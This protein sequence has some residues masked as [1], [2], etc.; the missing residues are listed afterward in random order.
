MERQDKP[1]ILILHPLF[2]AGEDLQK[3]GVFSALEKRY[4]LV[5]IDLP[6]HGSKMGHAFG[7]LD[8]VVGAVANEL[9]V[10]EA[11]TDFVASIGLSLGA[12][13]LLELQAR[14][15]ELGLC[16]LDGLVLFDD[17]RVTLK[18][19][20]GTMRRVRL[21]SKMAPW[22]VRWIFTKLYGPVC[23]AAMLR[24]SQA[25]E[26]KSLCKILEGCCSPLPTLTAG[27][28]RKI[29]FLFG[30]KEDSYKHIMTLTNKY[31]KAE[32]LVQENYDH[33]QFCANETKDYCALVE[34][35]IAGN[36]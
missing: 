28:L 13:I 26:W 7:E 30:G 12:R 29:R 20:L 4:R 22:L 35:L 33:I 1:A 14:G 3:Q 8:Q 25:M 34:R 6:S 31:P 36:E 23:G 27:Q 15:H 17:P 21:F 10:R 32:V 9:M 2:L 5:F 18:Q 24:H 11:G 16:I 19:S